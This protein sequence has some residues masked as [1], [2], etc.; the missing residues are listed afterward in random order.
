M[1][2]SIKK[3]ELVRLGIIFVAILIT[4]ISQAYSN[5]FNVAGK[6]TTVSNKQTYV[7][8][9]NKV[10]NNNYY[11]SKGILSGLS[12]NTTPS[13]EP[14][15][16]CNGQI[17]LGTVSWP[18]KVAAKGWPFRYEYVVPPISCSENHTTYLP[19]AFF[20]DVMFYVIILAGLY[21]IWE[22]N[23]P[24]KKNLKPKK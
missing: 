13:P 6:L 12:V 9:N 2:I 1:H 23:T 14:N 16:D 17:F 11:V 5:T 3:A 7:P 10:N 8:F 19:V 15:S 4:I 21:F 22:K 24:I 20:S 18:L